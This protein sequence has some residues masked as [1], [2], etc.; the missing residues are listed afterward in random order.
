MANSLGAHTTPALGPT[1]MCVRL[2]TSELNPQT[3][4]TGGQEDL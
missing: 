1:L 3:E 4:R 2:L